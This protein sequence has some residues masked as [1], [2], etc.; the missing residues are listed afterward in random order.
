[1]S[2]AQDRR[3]ER[4]FSFAGSIATPMPA[5]RSNV[6]AHARSSEPVASPSL[7]LT[8]SHHGEFCFF[9]HNGSSM[10]ILCTTGFVLHK[11]ACFSTR[12][13][14]SWS[15]GGLCRA[16]RREKTPFSPSL[17]LFEHSQQWWEKIVVI[18]EY[19]CQGS[20]LALSLRVREFLISHTI[21]NVAMNLKPLRLI[22]VW[23]L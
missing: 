17:R 20:G 3:H 22:S 11:V 13:Q 7:V 10:C 14:G 19:P 1:M 12:T 9:L 8:S 2:F 21:S 5:Y 18:P 16:H 4:A 23:K 15:T 6:T